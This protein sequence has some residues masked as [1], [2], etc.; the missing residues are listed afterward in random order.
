[1]PVYSF[2]CDNEDGGCGHNYEIVKSMSEIEGFKPKCPKCKKKKSFQNFGGVNVI[3]GPKTL[4]SLA[5][6]NTAKMSAD[7][8][9]YIY[10]KNNAY[11]KQKF[12]GTLPKGGKIVRNNE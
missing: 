6:K 12:S 11:R 4:G 5:D 9:H 2:T 3:E 10:E 7:E 8:K 1:M